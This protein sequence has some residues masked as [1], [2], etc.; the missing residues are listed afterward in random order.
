MSVA[1]SS[2]RGSSRVSTESWIL[3]KFWNLLSNF[4]DLETVCKI[5]VKSWKMVKSLEFFFLFLS[6]SKCFMSGSF[7]F[8]WNLIQSYP[9]VCNSSWKKL[10]SCVFFRSLLITYLITL[11]L[12]KKL[13]FGKKTGKSLEFES[14]NCTNLG[15]ADREKLRENRV[16]LGKREGTIVL[17]SY[18]FL[19]APFFARSLFHCSPTFFARLHWPRAW[20]RLVC[21]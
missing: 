4:P 15:K 1:F 2:L 16:G 10:C 14:K 6:H 17:A 20:H 21:F 5:E 18:V 7:G 19:F 9:Y 12:E 11:S 13:C 3:E 8:W